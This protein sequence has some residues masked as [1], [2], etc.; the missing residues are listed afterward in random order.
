MICVAAGL[1]MSGRKVFCFAITPF[2][3]GRVFDQIKVSIALMR[4]PVCLVAIGAGFSYDDAG[5]THYGVEDMGIMKNLKG[6]EIIS[7]YDAVSAKEAALQALHSPAFRYV[8]LDRHV[9]PDITL[10]YQ[11]DTSPA[12]TI[13]TSGAMGETSKKIAE[14]MN[15]SAVRMLTVFPF[16]PLVPLHGERLIVLEEH[17]YT[18]GLGESVAA[19]MKD[20]GDE[21]PLL[22]C[23]IPDHYEWENGGRAHLWKRAGLDVESL[24]EK[25]S[26][27]LSQ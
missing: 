1:A 15:L 19:W 21:R 22:R 9:L 18:G 12:A 23:A 14:S 17:F 4:L 13:L 11:L 20:R 16:D 2:I 6:I 26:K 25:I 5:P 3:T 10:P 27:W 24:T 8:R 7:P